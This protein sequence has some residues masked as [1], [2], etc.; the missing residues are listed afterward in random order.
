M[1][2]RKKKHA[3]ERI[4]ACSEYLIKDNTENKGA[5]KCFFEERNG[6]CNG[7]AL[8]IGCGKGTFVTT[9][10]KQNPDICFVAIERVKDVLVMA[11]EKAKNECLNNLVFMN[12]DAANLPEYFG[13]EELDNIYLNFPDPWHKERHS[14]RRLTAPSFLRL[15]REVLKE[16]GAIFFKTDNDPLFEFS[17]ITFEE[18]KYVLKNVTFDLHKEE[19]DWN[20]RTEYESTFSEK[21]FKIKRLEAWLK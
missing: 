2:A 18:E 20:V 3:D 16:D 14:K 5:W 11:L 9:L 4:A 10:A 1:R 19:P 8:E 12:A 17:L 13:E 7:I 21:G 15:Y 6:T